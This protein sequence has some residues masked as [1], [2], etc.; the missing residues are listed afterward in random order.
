[1]LVLMLFI[2]LCC[3]DDY[4]SELGALTEMVVVWN[5]GAESELLL[6]CCITFLDRVDFHSKFTVMHSVH[7]VHFSFAIIGL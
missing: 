1:M 2:I 4:G 7:S 6:P 3:S 5:Q